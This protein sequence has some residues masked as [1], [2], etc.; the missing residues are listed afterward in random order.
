MSVNI[1]DMRELY[2]F[3]STYVLTAQYM[4]PMR[5]GGRTWIDVQPLIGRFCGAFVNID[6]TTP[7]GCATTVDVLVYRYVTVV[8]LIICLSTVNV[9]MY[10]YAQ[11]QHFRPELRVSLGE[12]DEVVEQ[13]VSGFRSCHCSACG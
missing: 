13:V 9:M 11:P 10:S 12:T 3:D 2:V 5:A 1:G 4:L 8:T 7:K 6:V